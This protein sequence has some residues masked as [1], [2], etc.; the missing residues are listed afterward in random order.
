MLDKKQ[1]KDLRFIEREIEEFSDLLGDKRLLT[2]N[3]VSYVLNLLED[4]ITMTVVDAIELYKEINDL[5]K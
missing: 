2:L 1:L 3:C 4:D 5:L